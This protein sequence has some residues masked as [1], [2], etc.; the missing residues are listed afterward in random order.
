MSSL[1]SHMSSVNDDS[2][3]LLSYFASLFLGNCFLVILLQTNSGLF[4]GVSIKMIICITFV[5]NAWFLQS[6]NFYSVMCIFKCF[7]WIRL[8][9]NTVFLVDSCGCWAFSKWNEAYINAFS[10]VVTFLEQRLKCKE[11]FSSN[12]TIAKTELTKTIPLG[13]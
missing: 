3:I 10:L 4:S 13:Y 7:C 12:H 6:S 8:L 2:L 9:L 1:S 5:F 11:H